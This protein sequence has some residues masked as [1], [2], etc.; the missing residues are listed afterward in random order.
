MRSHG[1]TDFPDPNSNG[2]F[3]SSGNGN[4]SQ[5]IMQAAQDACQHL[6]PSG[7]QPSPQQNAQ[8][9][10]SALKFSRCMR[11]HG[12]SNFPDP[13]VSGGSVGFPLGQG[14]DTR[15]PG[16]QAAQRACQ[17]SGPGAS[18]SNSGS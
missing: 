2:N 14:I 3:Q 10:K 8:A 15:S 7:G 11:S 9:A 13:Q 17:S 6:L 16:F 5:A 18:N 12:V 4:V 1:A